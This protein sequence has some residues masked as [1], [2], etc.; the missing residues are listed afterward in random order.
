MTPRE[1]DTGL[2]ALECRREAVAQMT[3][4]DRAVAALAGLIVRPDEIGV[5][6]GRIERGK[7]Q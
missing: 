3:P 1:Q 2:R 6:R 5:L 4:E 7:I